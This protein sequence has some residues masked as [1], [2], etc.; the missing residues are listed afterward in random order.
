MVITRNGLIGR[1]VRIRV[2]LGSC[3]AVE[4]VPILLLPTVDL[5]AQDW[6]DLYRAPSVS[7]W[8]VQVT[9]RV[10]QSSLVSSSSGMLLISLIVFCALSLQHRPLH[11]ELYRWSRLS[12]FPSYISCN[13]FR[14]F[15]FRTLSIAF[16]VNSDK[17]FGHCAE[18][19]GN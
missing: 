1:H 14:T 18:I 2:G 3:F 19:Y 13:S 16:R 15:N 11:D 8:T 7:L 9:W 12:S 5:T 10:I 6:D 17:H 4:L